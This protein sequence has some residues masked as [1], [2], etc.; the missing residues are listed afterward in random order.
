MWLKVQ[1]SLIF[2]MYGLKFLHLTLLVM[3]FHSLN[4]ICFVKSGTP[5]NL[6]VFEPHLNGLFIIWQRLVHWPTDVQIIDTTAVLKTTYTWHNVL[7]L[8]RKFGRVNL[9]CK[10]AYQS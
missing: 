2:V 10:G 1:E 9:V 5:C 3:K 8:T 6:H 4:L 7:S